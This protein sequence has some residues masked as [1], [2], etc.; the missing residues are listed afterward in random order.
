[1]KLQSEYASLKDLLKETAT[2]SQ[3]Q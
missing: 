2:K 3:K 1:M